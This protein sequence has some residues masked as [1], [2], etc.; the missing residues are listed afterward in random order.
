MKKE[1]APQKG[2]VN[3]PLVNPNA[4]GIDIGDTIHAVAVPEDRDTVRVRSFGSM[5]CDLLDIAEWLLKCRIDTVAVNSTQIDPLPPFQI[6]P[7]KTI[8]KRP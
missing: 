2:V 6:D 5:T 3:M 7:F 4:A 1:K 8:S